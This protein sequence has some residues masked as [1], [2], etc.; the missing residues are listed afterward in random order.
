MI[1]YNIK[2]GRRTSSYNAE[3][4]WGL[5]RAVAIWILRSSWVKLLLLKFYPFCCRRVLCALLDSADICWCDF[6][7]Q[8]LR[9]M[10]WLTFMFL[11][12]I[13]SIALIPHR[14]TGFL[15]ATLSECGAPGGGGLLKDFCFL[16]EWILSINSEQ[17]NVILVC[18]P[19]WEHVAYNWNVVLL[20]V[21]AVS[22]PST[23]QTL[24]RKRGPNQRVR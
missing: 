11:V 22:S 15:M 1:N 16:Q 7:W 23:L 20:T 5:S 19:G 18:Y 4:V 17:A 10:V 12:R 2:K 24:T 13:C 14:S 21:S 8:S 3:M 9:R 6:T